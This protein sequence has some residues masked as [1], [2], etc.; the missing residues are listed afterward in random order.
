MATW[1][2]HGRIDGPIVMIGF[3]SIGRGT[4]P[5]IERHFKFDKDRFV[6]IDPRR[7]ATAACSTSAASAS[8]RRRVTRDNYRDAADAAADRRRRP[9][10]LRQPVGRHL[11]A[12]HHGALPRARRALHRHR[13]RAVARLLFRHRARDRRRAPTTRCARRCSTPSARNARRHRPRSPAAAP[14]P[15]WCRGSSSRRCSTSPATPGVELTRAEDAAR[16]GR[17]LMQRVGVKGIHIAERDTQRAKQPKPMDVFVNTWS[18]EGFISE[19]LQP[20]ELGWGT[21]EKWMPENGRHARAT[22]A[23]RRSICCSRAPTRACAPGA[24]RRARNTASWSRTTS[25]SRSPTTSPCARGGK[26]GLP[27]DLPLRLPSL[28]RR[29]AVAARDVRRRPA[30]CRTSITSS[31]RTRSSTASTS[32][33]CCSTATTRTPIG[34]ARS[35]RS[36]RRASSRPTRTP[37]ACR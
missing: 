37:P 28:Q 18:V 26:V 33:A 15:A 19:G 25:R 1:P 7:Q 21:H 20:A 6:V 27:A 10:L 5:L 2:V 3:G 17:S 34:T 22:A 8:S 12:R 11:L 30:R 29:G 35:S 4:L 32:S 23:R 14:I 16:T 31:T 13:G 9:G 24:R 36:R